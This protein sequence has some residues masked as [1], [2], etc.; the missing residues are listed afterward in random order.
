MCCLTVV[1]D[2]AISQVVNLTPMK[3]LYALIAAGQQ[4]LRTPRGCWVIFKQVHV[5]QFK[6]KLYGARETCVEGVSDAAP[7]QS[8]YSSVST[9]VQSSTAPSV[10]LKSELQNTIGSRSV[11]GLVADLWKE[12][13][14]QK[15]LTTEAESSELLTASPS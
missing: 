13:T 6:I 9:L 2:S 12:G 1:Y 10:E 14:F 3:S 4:T 7:L 8:G 11:A 15:R 5:S